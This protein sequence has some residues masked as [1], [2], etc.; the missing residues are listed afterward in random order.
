MR[1][2]RFTWLGIVGILLLLLGACESAPAPIPTSVPTPSPAARTGQP[3]LEVPPLPELKEVKVDPKV[4]ALLVLDMQKQSC[5]TERR[6]SCVESIPRVKALLEQARAK[7]M[8]VVYSLTRGAQATD[9]VSELAPL[10][11]EPMVVSGPDKFIGTELESI[12]K[13]KNITQV[14]VTGTAAHGAVLH[15][16]TGAAFRGFS[17]VVPVDGMSAEPFSEYYTAWHLANAPG[18]RDRVTISRSDKIKI[19]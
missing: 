17:A 6:P 7:G 3:S 16:A 19:E 1:K 18:A 12:L 13:G 4:S 2:Q 5:S 11:G 14:I 10:G 9:V 15:T 8:L